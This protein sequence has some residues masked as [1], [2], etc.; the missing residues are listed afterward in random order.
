MKKLYLILCFSLFT[1][2]TLAAGNEPGGKFAYSGFSGGMML[3]TGYVGG[4]KSTLV[5]SGGAVVSSQ[6]MAGMPT[7]IGGAVRIHLGNWLRIG[8]EGYVSTLQYGKYD[9][10]IRIGWGGVLAD[11]IWRRKKLSPFAGFTVGGGSARN[12]TLTAK[13]PV[14]FEVEQNSS[15][16]KYSFMCLVPFAG[17]EFAA[18]ARIRIMLKADYMVNLTGRR[19]DFVSGP[20]VYIGFSFY[21]TKD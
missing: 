11:C 16:R 6:K 14:D 15:Y 4:G 3:H 17:V 10:N 7:G 13:T 20:R 1:F 12:L 21:R 19:K 18:S 2:T 9:S 8:S 5:A